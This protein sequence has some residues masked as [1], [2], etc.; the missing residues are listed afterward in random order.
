MDFCTRENSY[1][2]AYEL[3]PAGL[4]QYDQGS[5]RALCARPLITSLRRQMRRVFSDPDTAREKVS[6]S[7]KAI[8]RLTW[9]ASARKLLDTLLERM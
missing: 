3:I 1:L 4:L 8:R 2:I 7:F 9:E 6:R 5:P